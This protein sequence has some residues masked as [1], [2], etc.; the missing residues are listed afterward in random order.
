VR[1]LITGASGFAGGHLVHACDAAGDDVTPLSRHPIGDH[2]GGRAA[3]RVSEA[4]V[5]LRDAAQVRDAM[6][7]AAPEVVYHLAALSSV[8]RSWQEPAITLA[9]NTATAVNVLEA[10]RH[11]AP[12]ARLVW[13]GSCEV[14]GPPAKLPVEEDA[15]LAPANPYAV[16]KVT[17]DLLAAVYADAYDLDI[18]RARPFSHA[19][20]GQREIFI[21][22]SLARQAAQARLSGADHVRIVTGNPDTRRDFT[23]VRD[24]VRAYR[25]LAASAPRGIYNVSSGRSVS[26]REQVQLVARLLAPI[27][28]EHEIDPSRVRAHEVPELRGS[29]ARLT[30]ATGWEPEIP[31]EQT[32]ADTIAWWEDALSVTAS[33]AGRA[34]LR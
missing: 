34:D 29:H 4:I 7:E 20:P 10:V 24:V 5:D 17:G 12:A 30:A 21:L 8:G 6:R 2:P 14:Y 3:E 15:P 25:L 19:G 28:V 18:V 27:E 13:A 33:G 26:A 22:S 16:S 31:F 11:E 1:V 9:E 32:M 23:D